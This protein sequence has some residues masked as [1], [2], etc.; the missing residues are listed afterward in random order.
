MPRDRVTWLLC[1]YGEVL[2]YAQSPDDRR[3]LATACRRT[4]ADLRV[5]YWDSRPAYDRG[6]IT[7]EEYWAG[8]VGTP[9]Q[10]PD[11]QHLVELDVASWLSRNPDALAAAERAHSR[12]YRLAILS[13]APTELADGLEHVPWLARFETRFFSCRLRMTKPDRDV[14]MAV[15]DA[16][17]VRPENIVFFDDRSTNVEAA[18]EVGIQAHLFTGP[19]QFD[20]LPPV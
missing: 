3:A 18:A 7:A 17:A 14:Y 4:D 13:N 20:E 6:D 11:L 2:S 10:G 12:G 16:L 5:A 1:D 15:V 9:I 8:V 19:H